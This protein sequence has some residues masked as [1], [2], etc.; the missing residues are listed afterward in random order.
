M[1]STVEQG[2]TTFHSRLTP[3]ATETEAARKHRESIHSCLKNNFEITRFFR[4]G[5]FGNGTSIRNYSDVD[6]FA[7]LPST[8]I[9]ANSDSTLKKVWRTLDERFPNSGVGIRTPAIVVPF[10]TD[11]SESSD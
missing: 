8:E 10:G 7:S 5:S 2:F 3:T 11:G 9:T 4:A 6:Y 1:P